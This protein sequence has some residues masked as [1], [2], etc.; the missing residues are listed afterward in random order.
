MSAKHLTASA[1]RPGMGDGIVKWGRSVSATRHRRE[2][3]LK[4]GLRRAR[5]RLG[6]KLAREQT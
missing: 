1:A 3:G 5:R 2:V 4:K 6:K